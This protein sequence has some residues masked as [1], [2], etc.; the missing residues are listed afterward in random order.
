MQNSNFSRRLSFSLFLKE[1]AK[2][3]GPAIAALLILLVALP[4]C[5]SSDKPGPDDLKPAEL[6][7]K[8]VKVVGKIRVIRGTP[9]TQLK[10][11]KR[12]EIT[13]SLTKL[14]KNVYNGKII[15]MEGIIEEEPDD[16]EP[17]E[18]KVK[19]VVHVIQAK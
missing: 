2:R 9:Y 16:D 14:I 17:G 5:S 8:L 15:S 13:G 10:N 7:A 6:N 19:A 1:T 4:A 3:T 12:F 18:F 11:G